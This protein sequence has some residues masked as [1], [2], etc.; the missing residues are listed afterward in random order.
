[1]KNIYIEIIK[2]KKIIQNF[3]ILINVFA[4]AGFIVS[5]FLEPSIWHK[6]G[7]KAGQFSAIAFIFSIIPG[8]LKRF[9]AKGFLQQLQLVLMT[10]RRQVG[11][12]MYVLGVLHYGWLKLLPNLIQD[13]GSLVAV[14]T[15][16]LLGTI[17][18]L[19][20]TPLF[21]TS[22]DFSI[23]IMGKYWKKLQSLVYPMI[24]I[25][26]GH[27]VF[28]NKIKPLSIIL[29][30]LGILEIISFV[31]VAKKRKKVILE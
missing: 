25:L 27:L 14:N 1:M 19:L 3:I 26:A 12:T 28:Q 2:R 13:Y 11:I 29:I 15:F 6:L 23:K 8:V 24:W 4:V 21:I 20:A 5:S 30:I 16:E 18:L 10:F 31:K 22:N 17:T 7:E 9:S